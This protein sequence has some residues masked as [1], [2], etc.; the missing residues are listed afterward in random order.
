MSLTGS[1]FCISDAVATAKA[2]VPL[3][4]RFLLDASTLLVYLNIMLDM[5]GLNCV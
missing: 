3:H 4:A 2:S 1:D 5:A